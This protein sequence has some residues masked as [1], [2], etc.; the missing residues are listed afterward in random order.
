MS[1]YKINTIILKHYRIQDFSIE[2]EP[3]RK[4]SKADL[5]QFTNTPSIPPT[6]QSTIQTKMIS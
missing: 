3:I 1:K 5:N 4:N 2:N 6:C